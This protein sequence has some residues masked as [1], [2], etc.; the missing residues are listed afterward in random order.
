[1]IGNIRKLLYEQR[2][3]RCKLMS[4]ESRRRRY[5]LLETLKIMKGITDM[6]YR[7]LFVL[8]N[9]P[10]GRGHNETNETMHQTQHPKVLLFAASH[11]RLE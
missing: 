2:L 4:L 7:K 6:D 10:N 8:H 11:R 5:D 9:E 3:G 1:M